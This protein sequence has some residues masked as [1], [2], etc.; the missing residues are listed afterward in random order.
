MFENYLQQ[1]TRKVMRT[2]E[3]AV[4][5]LAS[6]RQSLLTPEFILLALLSQSDS[7][8]VKILEHESNSNGG[9]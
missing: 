1:S 9:V 8:A 6:T 5:E 2:L 3:F 7:E 4:S